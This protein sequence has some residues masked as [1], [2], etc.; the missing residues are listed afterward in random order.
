MQQGVFLYVFP[1]ISTGRSPH[2]VTKDAAKAFGIGETDGN[3]DLCDG[4]CAVPQL[5]AGDLHP[6]PVENIMEC[7]AGNGFENAAE[8]G[9]AETAGF[10]DS[11]QIQRRGIT[12]VDHFQ[13]QFYACNIPKRTGGRRIA[14]D[15][16][17]VLEDQCA[18]AKKIAADGKT[19]KFRPGLPKGCGLPKQ[20]IEG[21]KNLAAFRKVKNA[22]GK[23]HVDQRAEIF[24]EKTGAEFRRQSAAG[25]AFGKFMRCHGTDENKIPGTE[26]QLFSFHD[27]GICAGETKAQLHFRMAVELKGRRRSCLKK[28]S[29]FSYQ[30]GLIQHRKPPPEVSIAQTGYPGKNK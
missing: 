25:A 30:Q 7:I 9:F 6:V 29:I 12:L 22:A 8:A 11:V 5:K 21:G 13:C 23:G 27:D 4:Q 10:T 26:P 16:K 1:A 15:G 2:K 19:G 28:I 24:S 17:K 14:R 3:C 18:D 20:I